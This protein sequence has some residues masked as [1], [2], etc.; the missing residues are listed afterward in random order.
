MELQR[1]PMNQKLKILGVLIV[2]VLTI[3]GLFFHFQR[4]E[5]SG[6]AVRPN[7]PLVHVQEVHRTDMMRHINLSGQ[8]VAEA[9]IA[10][11]PK[12]TGRVAEVYVKLGDRVHTG[13][14]LVRQELEDVELSI[15][16]KNAAA[17]AAAADA[18]EAEAT[19][20]ANYIK[21]KT[22][23]E[24]EQAKYDRNVYLFSIGAISQDTLDSVKQEYLASKAALEILENQAVDGGRAASVLSKQFAAEKASQATEILEKQREDMVLRAPRDGMIGYRNVEAGEIISAGTKVLS[25]VDNHN[26]FVDCTLSEGDAAILH[27][28]ENIDVSIDAAGRTYQG[29]IIYVSPAMN[30]SDKTYT[31]RIE[32]RGEEQDDLKA[33][34]FARSQL[35]ILQKEDTI[36]VPKEAIYRKNGMPAIFVLLADGTVEERMVK[37]GLMNDVEEEILSGLSDGEKVVL[38]N[39][40]K[41]ETGTVVEVAEAES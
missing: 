38:N 17:Q 15:E 31:V 36:F 7:R 27:A 9:D 24:L 21:V 11:A 34:L 19:Y 5:P 8:T 39:Q 10:L 1:Y 25:L 29:Q 32:L 16:E 26:I 33:G 37:I 40:D 28:G 6:K 4:N 22:A 35:D 41:L 23:F 13:D 14:A 2:C 18:L 20:N 3:G 12:Y 30:E